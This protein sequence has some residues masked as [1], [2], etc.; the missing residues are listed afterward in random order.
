MK[1]LVTGGAGFV[2]SHLV[3]RLA[4][5]GEEVT[6]VDNFRTGKLEFIKELLDEGKINLVEADLRNFEDVKEFFKGQD[7]VWHLAANADV[8]GGIKDTLVDLEEN[9]IATRNVLEAMRLA[10]VKKL[11]FFSSTQVYGEAKTPTPEDCS[12]MLPTNIYGASKLAAEAYI[13]AFSDNFGMTSYIFRPVNLVGIR[14]THGVI[15]DFMK[16]LE[17]N[18]RRMEILGNGKQMKSYMHIS[19]G[20]D[21]VDFALKKAKEKVNIYN[22]GSEDWISVAQLAE[23]IVG[24]MGLKNVKFE[25]TGGERGWVGDVPKVLLSMEKLRRLGWKPKY[26]SAEAVRKAVREILAEKGAGK[27]KKMAKTK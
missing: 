8:R 23:I 14:G 3:E 10:D 26:N 5:R 21:A 17:A 24:E 7:V 2:G 16:K 19:D 9:I 20:L 1:T 15:W 25:F 18:S 6:V 27:A 13:C 4:A 12:P 22:L 11:V